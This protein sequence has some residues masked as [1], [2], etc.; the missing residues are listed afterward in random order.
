MHRESVRFTEFHASPTCAPTRAALL[1]GRHEFHSGVTHTIFERERLALTSVTF[2]KLLRSSGY[3]TGI[4]GKWHLGDED[5]YQPNQRGFDRVFIHGAG[6]I[7]QSF[8]GSCGDVPGNSYYNPIVQRRH[9]RANK[10]ILHRCILRCRHGVDRQESPERRT[11]LLFYY[12]QRRMVR[13]MSLLVPQNPTPIKC[14][15]T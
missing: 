2:P 13:S 11:I 9:I 12:T 14:P 4:F 10:G 5:A 7:G 6:G 15:K 8:P 3:K 1:T